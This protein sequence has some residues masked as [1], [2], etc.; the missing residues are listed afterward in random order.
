MYP[1]PD[2]GWSPVAARER[3]GES[4]AY[5]VFDP[6]G[7][8]EAILN[9]I[10]TTTSR[11]GFFKQ[12]EL[13]A[14]GNFDLFEM[15]G[16]TSI[17]ALGAEYRQEDYAD[18]Y[19][20]QSAAGNVG[21]SSGNSSFGDRTLRSVFGEWILPITSNFELDVAARYDDYSDFGSTWNPKVA[22][23]WQPS[24]RP[25][26]IE[27][28]TMWADKQARLSS[29]ERAD[30]RIGATRSRSSPSAMRG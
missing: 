2:A 26:W 18:I 11:D 13:F 9:E 1:Y 8:S 4:G 16:G 15:G 28:Y 21:G 3:E 24:G 30:Q 6:S 5:N 25:Y 23:R 7:N 10:R 22:L 12:D 27:T 20:Q 17:V 19:D 29:I 14:V